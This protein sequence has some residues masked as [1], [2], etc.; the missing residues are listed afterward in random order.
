[1][2]KKSIIILIYHHHK[3]LNGGPDFIIYLII[4]T[5]LLIFFFTVTFKYMYKVYQQD[6]QQHN[7]PRSFLGHTCHVMV[8]KTVGM[9]CELHY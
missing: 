6:I 5:T 7:I 4:L 3:L 2:S 9:I 8:E 1:M